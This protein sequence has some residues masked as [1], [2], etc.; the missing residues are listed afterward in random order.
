MVHINKIIDADPHFVIDINTR[1]I[2][3]VSQSKTTIVQYDHNSERFS[4][5]LPRFVEGHDMMECNSVQVH[6]FL[7][8]NPDTEGVYEITDLTICEEDAEQICCTWLISQNVTQ[9]VGTLKFLLRF[10]CVA[11]DD[12][13][14]Y[15]WHTN[16][17]TG[18]SVSAGMNNANVIVEQ[19]A[20]VLEQWHRQ[21]LNELDQ[22]KNE[23]GEI[24]NDLAEILP[25][26]I[27]TFDDAPIKN[28]KNLVNSGSIF[29][30][31]K[32]KVDLTIVDEVDEDEMDK[33]VGNT[34][35]DASGYIEPMVYKIYP[36]VS[37]Y[38][39]EYSYLLIAYGYCTNDFSWDDTPNRFAR[40]ILIG[41]NNEIKTR[42]GEGTEWDSLT[43]TEWASFVTMNDLS[44]YTTT[45]EM[46]AAIQAAI[47]DSWEVGV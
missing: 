22:Y 17:F 4:F 46:N 8:A 19:H 12:T 21:L 44:S 37:P 31:L 42:T 16:P 26:V 32:A 30:S 43:W 39:D 18:I 11:E 2:K 7:G 47:L 1:N 35:V 34:T 38:A 27:T 14:E 23:L 20:D 9:T 24:K 25:K 45:E 41:K 5:T 13:I 40:Q 15:A 33:Y 10:A 6:Y 28:S 29:E 36:K 3:N